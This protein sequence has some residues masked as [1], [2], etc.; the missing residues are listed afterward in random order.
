MIMQ[1]SEEQQ[2]IISA[3]KDTIVTANPGTGK[4]TTLSLKVIKLLDEG[5]N[6][7]DILCITFTVKAKKELFDAIYKRGKGRFS[8]ADIMKINIHTFHSFAYNYLRDR[9]EI[10]GDI[11]GNNFLRFLILNSFEQN[12]ALNYEKEYIISEIMP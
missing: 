7:E 8:D 9:G 5:A 6:P 12:K 10:S 11:L 4:T 1:I 2:D 3:R